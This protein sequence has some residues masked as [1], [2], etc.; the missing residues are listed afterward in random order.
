MYYIDIEYWMMVD[1]FWSCMEGQCKGEE[2]EYGMEGWEKEKVVGW[3]EAVK[4]W[5]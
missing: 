2:S 4:D 5:E 3:G 1:A